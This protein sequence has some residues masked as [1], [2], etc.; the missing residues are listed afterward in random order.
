VSD[1]R[2]STTES[3]LA[4]SRGDIE[5]ARY[6]YRPPEPQ[7]E[8]PRPYFHPARTLAGELVTLYRPHDHVWHKGIAWSLPNV[9]RWTEPPEHEN[10]WGG[11]T[12]L[13]DAGYQQLANNGAMRHRTF[14]RLFASPDLVH[15]AHELDWVSQRGDRWV[16]ELRSFGVTV[17]DGAWVLSFATRLLNVGEAPLRF[18][19]P[20]TQ[21]RPNAGYGGLFWRG[22]RSF[23]GGAVLAP[24]VQGG[25]ELMG[26]TARWLGFTGKHDGRG[27]SSSIVFVSDPAG[28][29]DRWFVRSEIYA[30]IC[31]A[32]FFDTE[33]ELPPG[34]VLEFQYAVVIADGAADPD[35]A[36]RLADVGASALRRLDLLD[37]D[38]Q[39]VR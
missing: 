39:A 5:L 12:Y 22:P 14:R 21:G 34:E 19:S 38:Y 16:E 33:V 15:V 31:P 23:S 2:L 3:E 18:G 8:S 32:P 29:P 28:P 37:H 6:V 35:R 4:V 36:A 27:G 9:E 25:D 30:C 13:R 1:L 20:T 10:F 17:H 24:G 26:T 11:V 7:L